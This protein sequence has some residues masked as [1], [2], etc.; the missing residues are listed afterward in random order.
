MF[1]FPFFSWDQSCLCLVP[2]GMTHCDTYTNEFL[3]LIPFLI[4]GVSTRLANCNAV[5][6]CGRV[7]FIH[8]ENLNLFMEHFSCDQQ[9]LIITSL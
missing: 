3:Y 2:A 7:M 8:F 5:G 1:F 9:C 4:G 6:I